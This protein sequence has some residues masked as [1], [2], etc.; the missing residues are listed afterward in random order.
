MHRLAWDAML[1][2]FGRTT[3]TLMRI[4]R[5]NSAKA[6]LRPTG[7]QVLLVWPVHSITRPYLSLCFVIN[8]RSV[9]ALDLSSKARI[10]FSIDN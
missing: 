7:K 5:I 2:N 1:D 6:P 4:L 8:K 10:L 3:M 9:A